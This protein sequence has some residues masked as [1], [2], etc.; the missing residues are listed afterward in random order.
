MEKENLNDIKFDVA[1]DMLKD[2]KTEDK[3]ILDLPDWDMDSDE[4]YPLTYVA[5]LSGKKVF[6]RRMTLQDKSNFIEA[7][8]NLKN[9]IEF[10]AFAIAEMAHDENGD[11]IFKTQMQKN[12]ILRRTPEEI[13]SLYL[14]LFSVA[15]P[16]EY[17]KYLNKND[18]EQNNE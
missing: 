16:M 15:E 8:K 5:N 4:K 3:E 11:K 7:M 10:S 9:D 17:E 6:A 13:F 18:D 2:Y 1:K 12:S 14:K